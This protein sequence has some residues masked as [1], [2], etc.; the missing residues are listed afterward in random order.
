MDPRALRLRAYQLTRRWLRRLRLQRAFDIYGCQVLAAST[1]LRGRPSEWA[2]DELWMGE[3]GAGRGEWLSGADPGRT[4]EMERR[5]RAGYRC[6]AAA[7]G[8]GCSAYLW[9]AVGPQ[10]FR[11]HSLGHTWD[12][13]AGAAW[14]FDA[15]AHPLSVGTY[16]DL[17]RFTV[18]RL[19]GEGVG[20]T[21]SQ[22]EFGNQ[23][24]LRLLRRWG[25]EAVGTGLA[26]HCAG[27]PLCLKA[28]RLA[29]ASG[30]EAAAQVAAPSSRG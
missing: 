23:I 25:A 8:G 6:F 30:A 28:P 13:P 18:A 12:I 26:V 9:A 11:S 29:A 3:V 5:W 24:S 10:R 2:D 4:A 7:T 1:A 21:W 27:L 22:V 16:P 19:R 14:L 20:W 15:W 17:N